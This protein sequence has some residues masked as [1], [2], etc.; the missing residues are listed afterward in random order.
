M[1]R[2]ISV[3]LPLWP[4]DRL[5]RSAPEGIPGS[6]A[7]PLVLAGR[8]GNRRLV[9][10]ACAVA[11]DLGLTVGMPVSKAQALVPDL[12]VIPHDPAADAPTPSG[13]LPDPERPR[14]IHRHNSYVSLILSWQPQ[15]GARPCRTPVS[16]PRPRDRRSIEPAGRTG[17]FARLDPRSHS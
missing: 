8:V 12:Q 17:R 5:R 4:I 1:A 2:V 9:T 14:T 15:Y 7:R 16:W 6:D 13:S 10:A 11:Q 3:T